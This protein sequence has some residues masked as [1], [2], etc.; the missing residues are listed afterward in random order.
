MSAENERPQEIQSG[1]PTRVAFLTG[2]DTPSTRLSIESVCQI[3]GVEPVAVLIDTYTPPSNQRWKNLRRNIRREGISYLWRRGLRFV[4]DWLD[5]KA[6]RIVSEDDVKNL[7]RRAFPERSYSLEELGKRY[8]FA[9]IEAGNL[10]SPEAAELLRKTGAQLGVVLGTRILKR[11]TFSVPPRG[12]I[13][14]HKGKVPDYRGMPPGFWELYEQSPSAGVTVHFVDDG[15]DTGDIIGTGEIEIQ[16]FET[17]NSLRTKLDHLGAAVLADSVRRLQQGTAEPKKQPP[18]TRKAFT[19]PTRAQERELAMRAAHL[20]EEESDAKRIFK[21]GLY[22]FFYHSGIYRLRRSRSGGKAGRGAILLHHRVNDISDDSLTTN[23]RVFAEQLLLLSR[24][25]KVTA[26]RSIVDHVLLGS[27]IEPG[28]V[29]IHFDDC[30]R[31][32]YTEASRILKAMECPA[33]MFIATGFI[34]TDRV[35]EHDRAKYPHRFEN[36]RREDIPALMER[37]FEIGA[38]T[39]NH[40]DLGVID[41]QAAQQEITE[42]RKALEE[43]TGVP[44]PMFSFPF[45]KGTNIREEVR[46]L[47]REAGCSVLFSAYGGSV[48]GRSP[49]FDIPRVGTSSRYR[50][51]DLM[52]ELEGLSVSQLLSR[53]R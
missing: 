4:R 29:A 46:E 34:D 23:T 25:Y 21:A 20:R 22:L 6:H 36:L 48:T 1:H 18:S 38:H 53:F 51:L 31:D 5:A 47:V 32:V 35:F 10:N 11:S 7:L 45:G 49:R 27:R 28:S 14:L 24:F 40:V 50:A 12:S 39:V 9:V 3:A 43:I 44:I 41:R 37:G 17:V 16:P 26:T 33:T 52:M 2:G 19:K 15:L 13:N 30:Y 8:G 42:S